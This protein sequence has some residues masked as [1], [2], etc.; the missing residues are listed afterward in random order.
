MKIVI[1]SGGV[2]PSKELLLKELFHSSYLVCADSGANCLFNYGIVPHYLMGDFD[3]INKD[4]YKYFIEKECNIETFKRDKDYTDTKLALLKA[5]ELGA[6]E[7]VF[8]GC[9]GNRI[10]HTLGNL[11]LL[12][13]C[14]KLNIKCILKDDKNSVEI[15]NKPLK[16][17][18]KLG[19]YF[20][21]QAYSECVKDLT[22]S[23]AKF[24][25]IDYD[26]KIGDPLTISNEFL[27]CDV[28]INFSS[29]ELLIIFSID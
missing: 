15:S 4:V 2:P 26:L 19:Q 21:L 29:G 9:T 3:S 17:N 27:D 25:L 8:L 11:C 10:D 5:I 6:S 16:I 1:V 24:E 7:I 12:K 23:G 28:E 20:S 14:L 22:I 13:E 18:A